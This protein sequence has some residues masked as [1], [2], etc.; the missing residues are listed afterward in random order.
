MAARPSR[1]WFFCWN[2]GHGD[3]FHSQLHA[4][5]WSVDREQDNHDVNCRLAIADN[6]LQPVGQWYLL[7]TLHS[8]ETAGVAD[9]LATQ[10]VPRFQR[11]VRTRRS[12]KQAESEA[13]YG[14]IIVIFSY[15]VGL[16]T[17]D[18]VGNRKG[19]VHLVGAADAMRVLFESNSRASVPQYLTMSM[20][21][22]CPD[23]PG[24]KG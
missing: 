3:Y 19:C 14:G 7:R 9:S 18:D 20:S 12:S 16:S 21:G 6:G 13:R 5:I 10:N 2:E 23:L 4:M 11:M 15:G 24:W 1:G 17:L 22:P 8:L